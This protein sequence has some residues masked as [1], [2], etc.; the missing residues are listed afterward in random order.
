MRHLHL[1]HPAAQTLPTCSY[2]SAQWSPSTVLSTQQPAHKPAPHSANCW[3]GPSVLIRHQSVNGQIPAIT[4]SVSFAHQRAW[5][6]GEEL[7]LWCSKARWHVTA[8]AFN[9]FCSNFEAQSTIPIFTR[10]IPNHLCPIQQIIYELHSE[11]KRP[12]R[13]SE[14]LFGWISP[15][16]T[17]QIIG[18]ALQYLGKHKRPPCVSDRLFGLD[19][20]LN[21]AH[22][23]AQAIR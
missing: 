4:V 9:V 5:G 22:P 21:A 14:G 7:T 12:P 10:K 11:H 17:Q 19:P 6:Y 18:Q 15:L 3:W 2:S 8:V 20:R 1:A 23:P 13:I 16:P